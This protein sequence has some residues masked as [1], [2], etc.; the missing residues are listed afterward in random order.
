MAQFEVYRYFVLVKHRKGKTVVA[1]SVMPYTDKY[2][3]K[4]LSI[5]YIEECEDL[6]LSSG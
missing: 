2:A 3:A 4:V 6:W 1:R 5:V